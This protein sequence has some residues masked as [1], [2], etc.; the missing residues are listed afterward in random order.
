[1]N[2]CMLE[3]V[4]PTLEKTQKDYEK[5]P[6]KHPLYPEEWKKFWNRRYKELQSGW[7]SI[8]VVILKII[9]LFFF[10]FREKRSVQT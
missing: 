3:L 5:N 10:Y 4:L 6:E 9:C 8:C 7:F 1:M 2:R